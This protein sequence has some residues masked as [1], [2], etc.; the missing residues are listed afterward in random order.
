MESRTDLAQITFDSG[1]ER[2]ER[3][4]QEPRLDDRYMKARVRD[5]VV[6]LGAIVKIAPVDPEQLGIGDWSYDGAAIAG[7]VFHLRSSCRSKPYHEV[8]VRL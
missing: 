2:R 1:D 8:D 3:R 5:Q 4:G 6:V 7:R